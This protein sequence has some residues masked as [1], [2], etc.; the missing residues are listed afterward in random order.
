MKA[1]LPGSS[2]RLRGWRSAHLR[3][4]TIGTRAISAPPS[5]GRMEFR[6]TAR[7]GLTTFCIDRLIALPAATATRRLI[8]SAG[9]VLTRVRIAGPPPR[10]AG[11]PATDAPVAHVSRGSVPLGVKAV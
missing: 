9:I 6:P 11:A 4:Q 7:G 10:P 3:H 5:W 2:R 8:G 1:A